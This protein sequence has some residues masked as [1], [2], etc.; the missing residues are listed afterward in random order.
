MITVGITVVA[1]IA[2]PAVPVVRPV[3]AIIPIRSVVGIAVRIVVSIW[4]VS[5]ARAS[6]P[7]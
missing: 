7:N 3:V 4:I 2:M 6:E 5:V 1:I